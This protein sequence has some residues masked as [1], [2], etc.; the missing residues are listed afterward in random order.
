VQSP[1]FV[2]FLDAE[3]IDSETAQMYFEYPVNQYTG[4]G[5]ASFTDLMIIDSSKSIAIEAKNTESKYETV[6][7]WLGNSVNKRNVLIGWLGLINSKLTLSITSEDI[8]EV[9]YQMI[10]RLASA[11]SVAD[12]EPVLLY[13]YFGN[14][15]KMREYYI[16]NL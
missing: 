7:K 8:S 5:K 13:L 4:K 12:K 3:K 9:P 14:S 2:W 6:K 16:K 11:C 15:Q 1:Q 10:H